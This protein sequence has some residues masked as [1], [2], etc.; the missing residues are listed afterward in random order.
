MFDHRID[1]EQP[2]FLLLLGVLPLLWV[3][4]YRS[5]AGLGSVRRLMA[6][7]LRSLVLMLFIFALAEVQLV[8]V[9]DRVAVIYLLDQSLSIPEA[10]R[11][12]MLEYFN[13]SVL[14]HRKRDDYAGVIVFGRDAAIE[15]PPYDDDV[16]LPGR[17][18]SQFDPEHTNMAGALRLAQ[19]SFPENAAKRI[20]IIS[21]GIENLGNSLEQA[22][23]II[24]A[25]IGIDVQPVR[26]GARRDVA[27]EKVTV[28]SDLRKGEPFDL[29]VV[30]NNTG[31]A[32]EEDT[33]DVSGRLVISAR[34]GNEPDVV[35]EEEI[36]LSP[37]KRFF[38]LSQKL[39][40]PGS[41][42]YEAQF[43]PDQPKN[44][45][46]GQNNRATAF[47]HIRGSGQVLLIENSDSPGEFDQMVDELRNNDLEVEVR[48]SNQLFAS[49]PELQQY[50]TVL[51]AN[52]PREHFTDPQITMLVRNTEMG[53]GLMMLGGPSSFGAGGWINTELEEAMPVEFQIKAAKVV[54]KG[55]LAL[56]MHASE[57][58]DGNHWQKKIAEAALNTL[59]AQDYCGVLHW[60][61]NEKW[62]WR[63]GLIPV[64]G[65]RNMM[66]GRLGKMMPGDMPDFGPTMEMARKGFA[67]L[68]DAAVKHMII[69]SDGDPAPPSRA[70]LQGLRAGGVTVS[71]VAVGSHGMLGADVMR[72][73]ASTT[74]GK[75]YVVR[76]PNALPRIFQKEARRVA[77]P[78]IYENPEGFR[79]YLNYPN[80]LVS[81]LEGELPPITGFVMTSVKEHPLVE[82]PL[83]SPLPTTTPRNNAILANWTY[84]LGHAAVFTSDAGAR[85]T[86]G[87]LGWDGYGKLFTQSVRWS[88][89]PTGDTGKFNV[90]TQIEDQKVRIIVTALDKNDEFLNYLDM[91]GNVLGPDMKGN[92]L[93]FEQVAPGRYVA[94]FDALD[95]GIYF[96]SVV[97]GPDQAPLRVGVN[98]PYS[99][100]FRNHSTNASLLEGLAGLTPRGGES[101]QVIESPDGVYSAESL[102]GVDP[103]RRTLSKA[104][105][106]QHVW[107]YFVL[108]GSCLF[109]F[110]VMI[111]R[112]SINFMWVGPL[113]I[114]TWNWIRGRETEAPPSQYMERLRSRKSEVS[115]SLAQ[116]TAATRFEPESDSTQ[117]RDT[118]DAISEELAAKPQ[119]TDP[120]SK[121]EK[122]T[123]LKPQQ[124]EEEED[125]TSRL[126]KA[127]KKVWDDR[128]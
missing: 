14:E 125:Y 106:S 110:D 35:A 51:L 74:G 111:R 97:P 99:A 16:Q 116:R 117:N 123:S 80:E 72:R 92:S 82:V 121:T 44:D 29:R 21:D 53:S 62:L 71:T 66:L 124:Q 2:W 10:H 8:R 120:G 30:L 28:P 22:Q 50:D 31:E 67:Q 61:G 33:G 11:Q 70:I 79:P 112:L 94:S 5:L 104:T 47:T 95:S 57:M 6:I 54:P 122:L 19:A 52:V 98:I 23:G 37:G 88:M 86:K 20:V 93:D 34:R 69:I 40:Q 27:V 43:I 13:R 39:E 108:L 48:R 128:K 9:S 90:A 107:H 65:N 119:A 78:L 81:G 83:M 49:L 68:Q 64:A 12:T 15:I 3:M 89:R 55:A 24:D 76:N 46:L 38:R 118:P 101:G 126:L 18:E 7:V 102:L 60:D 36:T 4:S 103:Y 114:R 45:A 63:G 100:E 77:R 85:W 56:I 84:G 105:S 115:E 91:G 109:F 41:I 17:I 59:G 25:G 75:Y 87:W 1:F 127:K 58:A 26:Y 113:T 73:I 32:A 42:V 96:A